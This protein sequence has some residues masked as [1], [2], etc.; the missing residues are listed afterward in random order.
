[1]KDKGFRRRFPKNRQTVLEIIRAAKSVPAFPLETT[2]PVAKI[3]AAR[4]TA[5]V[6]VGWTAMFAKAFA[7]VCDENE[8]LREAF[9]SLP[10]AQLY[11]HPTS[12]CSVTVHR[13]DDAG[14]D[15][16]IWGRIENAS[17]KSLLEIQKYLNDC[18]TLPL[19]EVYRDGLRLE[20]TLWF[21]RKVA[22][23]WIMR[24]SGRKKSKLIGTFSISSLG[25]RGCLNMFHPLITTSSIAFGPM[26][27]DGDMQ[28]VLICDHRVMDG[29]VGA[30][31]LQSLSNVMQ[32]SILDELNTLAIRSNA[33]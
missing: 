26:N 20:T 1:M 22:W 2:I 5:A 23:W 25:G 7:K 27:L 21:I 31:A 11:R 4:K 30:A 18:V 17:S 9:I 13:K 10:F 8:S 32:T 19:S 28:V 6:R 24:C 33:A 12:V 15:R 16:L 29:M 14:T 3:E